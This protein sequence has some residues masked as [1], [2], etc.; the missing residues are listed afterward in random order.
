MS[1]TKAPKL[2]FSLR[3]VCEILSFNNKR[4]YLRLVKCTSAGN[5]EDLSK[6]ALP[7]FLVTKSIMA[8]CHECKSFST[9]QTGFHKEHLG[10]KRL[11]TANPWPQ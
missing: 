10:H 3:K 8:Y 9:V 6:N 7:F 2:E 11:T 1:N 4:L 5:N